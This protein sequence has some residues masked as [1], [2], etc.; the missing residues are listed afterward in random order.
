[1]IIDLGFVLFYNA[2]E[3][4]DPFGVRSI[5]EACVENNRWDCPQSSSIDLSVWPSLF[6]WYTRFF[7][8]SLRCSSSPWDSFSWGAIYRY[9][10]STEH[11][12]LSCVGTPLFFSHCS[13][14]AA[15][16]GGV[17]CMWA[18]I[19]GGE[20]QSSDLEER[21]LWRRGRKH[22]WVEGEFMKEGSWA[23]PP[24]LNICHYRLLM[25]H[26]VFWRLRKLL[27]VLV[28]T[29]VNSGRF[30]SMHML[31]CWNAWSG[32]VCPCRWVASGQ[33]NIF[34]DIITFLT[35]WWSTN[36]HEEG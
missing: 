33:A 7:P 13:V 18:D 19:G 23:V 14:I 34:E 32:S 20:T 21:V 1:M 12:T 29:W 9:V 35:S 10:R 27:Q 17:R 6:Q 36:N 15:S 8:N 31:Q 11:N 26:P 30:V 25:E 16:Q 5:L 2:R 4:C 3:N 28:K 22:S 24:I